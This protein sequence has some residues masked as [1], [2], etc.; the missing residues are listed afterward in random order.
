[1]PYSSIEE[2][3]APLESILSVSDVHL[4]TGSLICYRNVGEIAY[5]DTQP[6]LTEED[7][8]LLIKS[9][10]KKYDQWFE[11]YLKQR[12]FDFNYYSPAGV[13]YR[14]NAFFKLNNMAVAMRKISY[15][16]LPLETLMYDDVALAIKQ[17][18]LNQKTGM[19]LVTWPTGSGKTTSLIAMLEYLNLQRKE[20]IITIE[21]PIEFVFK[22]KNCLISQRELWSDTLSYANAMRSAMRE[23]PDI[24]FVGEIRD[25]DTAE[26]AM[27]LA[28]TGHLVF[29]TLHT[30]TAAT[31]VHRIIS[32]F[33]PEI[34]DSVKDRLAQSLLG[35]QSQ[36]LLQ[37][38]DG[39]GRVW[40]FEFMVNSTAVKNDIRKN[41]GRQIDAIIET[42]RQRGMISHIEYAKRLLAEGKID[43]SQIEWML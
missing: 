5:V 4:C 13:P 37:T 18:I 29:S 23:D 43:K 28:E 35:V 25:P 16:A 12:E 34:Q 22:Q 14:V 8:V 21:D 10:L 31:T 27:N 11:K 7:M 19:F 6:A 1:M 42:S 24:I 38:K 20:H 41:E 36:F 17:N 26:A 32:L 33:P 39:K 2:I 9:L 15:D 40:L 3:L 30:R